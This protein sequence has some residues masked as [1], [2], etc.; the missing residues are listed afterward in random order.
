M[1]LAFEVSYIGTG[2]YGSQQQS[3]KR[4]VMGDII[5][6]LCSLGVIS[7]AYEAD[8]SMSGRTDAGVHAKRQIIAFNTEHP[9]RAI[10]AVNKKLPPDI[11]FTGYAEVPP[12]FNPRFAARKRTYRYYFP[13][14]I[15]DVSYNYDDM[16]DAAG[17]FLGKH[18]FRS[19]SRPN[20]KSFERVV[21][22]SELWHEDDFFVYEIS[23]HSFLWH[24]VR[25]IAYTLDSVG[26][27]TLKAS[28]VTEALQNP[29]RKRFP[30]APP[31]GLILWDVDCGITFTPVNI[32]EKSL[33][34]T[35]DLLGHY[36]RLKKIS[37]I[38]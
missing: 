15:G 7:G 32:H 5:S 8:M 21:L 6:S 37:E 10:S 1:R 26:K 17:I 4:T 36:S 28:D 29:S 9:K 16:K 23:G 31:E 22:S 34:H 14:G 18:N 24:M 13:A 3:D 20:G 27:G 33:V 30:A 12:D 25:C 19:F 11:R 35:N 2:F 38:W